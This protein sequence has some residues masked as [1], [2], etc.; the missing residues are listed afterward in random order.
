MTTDNRSIGEYM[1]SKIQGSKLEVIENA[2]H[3]VFVDKPQAFNQALEAFLE[4]R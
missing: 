1:Q 3:A 4:A 2:G